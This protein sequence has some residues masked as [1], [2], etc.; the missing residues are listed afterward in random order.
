MNRFLRC[1]VLFLWLAFTLAC[2]RLPEYAQPRIVQVHEQ[3]ET[4]VTGFPYRPLTPADFRAASLSEQLAEHAERINA[5]ATVLIRVTAD[6]SFRLTSGNFNGQ[7]YY[8][9]SIGQLAFEAVMLPDRSWWNPKLPAN[10]RSYVLQHE[11]IH[12]ALTELA[13]RQLTSDSHKWASDVLVIELT[14]Q[15][16]LAELAQQINDRINAAMQASLKRQAQ[17]DEDTSLSYNPKWQHWWSSKVEDEL[18]KSHRK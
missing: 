10:M 2:A 5:H 1:A 14:P 9:G 18:K 4:L 17:F 12:F 11:Q 6:S 3:R 13:A 8:F 15:E 7:S 16:V